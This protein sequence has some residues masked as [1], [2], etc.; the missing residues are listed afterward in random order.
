L[1]AWGGLRRAEVAALD[2]GDFDPA[3]GRRRVCG[4]GGHEE[5]VALSD[6]AC[7]IVAAYLA[8]HRPDAPS[9]AP[10]F[11]KGDLRS[12]QE[13]LRHRHI[14]TTTLY[15]RLSKPKMKRVVSLFDGNDKAGGSR[16]APG[17]REF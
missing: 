16:P 7:Q 6:R 12:V 14:Q 10:M 1:L 15:T 2:V 5:A 17:G 9:H 11:V 4:K 8:A 13:H 3:F